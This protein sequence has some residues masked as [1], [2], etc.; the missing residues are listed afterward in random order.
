MLGGFFQALRWGWEPWLAPLTGRLSDQRFGRTKMLAG[1][2]AL[3]AVSFA[4][5]A[6]PLPLPLWFPCILFMQISATMLTT[7]NDAAAADR[8]SKAGD[9]ALLMAYALCVDAGAALGPLIA[10]GMNEFCGLSAV[11]ACCAGL[12]VVL[13]IRRRRT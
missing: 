10:Y 3:G 7:L 1:S 11:Y 4:A 6:S 8:A 12:F 2:F 13:M 5:L 9:R